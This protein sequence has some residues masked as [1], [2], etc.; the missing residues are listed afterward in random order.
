M[1]AKRDPKGKFF[2]SKDY[3]TTLKGLAA[4]IVVFVHF[5][6]EYQNPVQDMIGSFA[7]VAVTIFFLFSA[8]GMQYGIEKKN[9]YLRTFWLNRFANLV[10]PNWMINM[11]T[12]MIVLLF[13]DSSV[14]SG[15]VFR[16]NHYVWVLLEYCVVFFIIEFLHRRYSLYSRRTADLLLISTVV[17]KTGAA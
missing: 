12:A 16:L 9:G 14:V 17:G 11:V 3:T 5:P 15:N 6:E 13:A 4:L 1:G 7:Y 8:Y 2:L 10:I